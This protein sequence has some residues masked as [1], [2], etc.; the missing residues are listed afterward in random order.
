MKQDDTTKILGILAAMQDQFADMQR[1][2]DGLE[3]RFDGLEGRF[4][5][6][7]GRFDGLEGRFDGL[8]G[9]F[10]GLEGRFGGLEGRFDKL[11]VE[12]SDL[13][14]GMN[15]QFDAAAGA[16]AELEAKMDSKFADIENKIDKIIGRIEDDDT[17]RVALTSQVNRHENWI[18]KAAPKLNVKYSD[19]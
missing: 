15:Q 8:Q 7:E 1:R 16:H 4:D 12:V 9:R 14:E 19:S 10:D 17:E 18:K 13:K 11:E 5:G 6:L 2:F 3:G